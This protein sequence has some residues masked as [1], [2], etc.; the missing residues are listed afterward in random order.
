[1]RMRTVIPGAFTVRHALV[2]LVGIAVGL[3][4]MA[5]LA[6]IDEHTTGALPRRYVPWTRADNRI[7]SAFAKIMT[8]HSRSQALPPSSTAT[9]S[10][11]RT[12]TARRSGALPRRDPD[13]RPATPRGGAE[14]RGAHANAAR[15]PVRTDAHA[16]VQAEAGA[17]ADASAGA[18]A[19]T[20]EQADIRPPARQG[21][22][23]TAPAPARA[24]ARTTTQAG[25][26]TPVQAPPSH[27]SAA[28]MSGAWS[29][30]GVPGR[31]QRDQAADLNVS[32]TAPPTVRPGGTYAYRIVITNRGP[33][34]PDAVT[35]RTILPKDVVR[36]GSSLPDGV[37]GY[38]GG[39]DATLVLRRLPA[40][41]ST[42]ATFV[43]RARP[44]ARGDLVARSRIIY[45]GGAR[46]H[47]LRDNTATVTTRVG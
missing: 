6:S 18:G 8:S 22:R 2:A 45:I 30:F 10:L 42:A 3:P 21:T 11:P 27:A 16:P 15:G 5:A 40:G 19:R 29:P 43:V 20:S 13:R 4:A 35:I 36:T 9:G 25:P 39:R 37:G 24:G 47:R 38:A 31:P 14:A 28:D 26:R 7:H 17:P 12:P 1:M 23:V 41:G 46:D 44:N 33:G 32:L 34:A